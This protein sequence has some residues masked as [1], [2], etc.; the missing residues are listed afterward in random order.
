MKKSVLAAKTAAVKRDTKDALQ[1]L[2]NNINKGQRKQLAKREEIKAL[3][4]RYGVDAVD[5]VDA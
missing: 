2:W 4:E 3:L 1:L 5:A